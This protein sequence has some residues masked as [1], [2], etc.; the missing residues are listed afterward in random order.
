MNTKKV[1][2]NW[3]EIH[4]YEAEIEIP[5]NLSYQDEMRWVEETMKDWSMTVHEPYEISLDWDSFEV[6]DV[7]EEGS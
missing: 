4:Y 7:D 1:R 5:N 2:A 6:E 3:C